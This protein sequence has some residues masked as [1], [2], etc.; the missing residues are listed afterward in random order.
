M[1]HVVMSWSIEY[2]RG[3]LEEPRGTKL[4][5]YCEKTLSFCEKT[6]GPLISR[7]NISM[8]YFL[9]LKLGSRDCRR[10]LVTRMHPST[11]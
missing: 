7:V 2:P 11:Y 8:K 9:K 1:R 3:R 10:C 6:L 5:E 4:G